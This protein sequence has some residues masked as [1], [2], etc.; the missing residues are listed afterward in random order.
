MGLGITEPP[1]PNET[2]ISCGLRSR[3]T[4]RLCP[5]ERPARGGHRRP[6]LLR[7]ATPCLGA[8]DEREHQW[9][10]APVRPE[11]AE[12]GASHPARLQHARGH[13]ELPTPEAAR[14]PYPGGLLWPDRTGRRTAIGENVA[15]Q[16]CYQ[17]ACLWPL[18]D[19]PLLTQ[20][21]DD[22]IAMPV[23]AVLLKT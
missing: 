4:R 2:R 7:H 9:V 20:P 12:H 11:W 22:V 18:L 8:P 23:L 15:L 10:G 5:T 21:L 14:F 6:L 1:L 13:R 3:Q 16:S 19:K 17:L